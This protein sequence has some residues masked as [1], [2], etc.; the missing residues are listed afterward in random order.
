MVRARTDRL[1]AGADRVLDGALLLL[2]TWT[3]VYH[4]SLLLGVGSTVALVVELAV[5]VSVVVVSRL[6]PWRPS[7]L[8]HRSVVEVR[9]EPATSLE[10]TRRRPVGL[11]LAAA[12][13]AAVAMA[14]DAPWG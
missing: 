4:L 12:L 1:A 8:N 14:L 3:V 10:T 11:T 2:A 13:V 6:G 7:H 9:G 5:L